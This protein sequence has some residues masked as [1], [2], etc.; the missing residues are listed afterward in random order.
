MFQ[1]FSLA[2]TPII[3]GILFSQINP[4]TQSFSFAYT[5][6]GCGGAEAYP[7]YHWAR[8]KVNPGRGHQSVAGLTHRNRQPFTLIFT[9]IRN[10]ELPI[11]L[12]PLN[13]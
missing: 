6:Q 8:G 4:S 10:S 9:P 5:C 13:K 7:S 11:N 12:T 2:G 3:L 1:S